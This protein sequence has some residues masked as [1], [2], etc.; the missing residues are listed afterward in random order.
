MSR[1]RHQV[2]RSAAG[3]V[4]DIAALQWEL[5]D[6]GLPR[7]QAAPLRLGAELDPETA[8]AD[9]QKR[10][11]RWWLIPLRLVGMVAS[12]LLLDDFIDVGGGGE[13]RPR[14]VGTVAA[15]SQAE[16]FVKALLHR[17]APLAGVKARWFAWSEDGDS[18]IVAQEERWDIE[19]AH[20]SPAFRWTPDD[21]R[22]ADI[23]SSARWWRRL[24]RFEFAD[25]SQVRMRQSPGTRRLLLAGGIGRRA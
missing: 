7:C 5:E 1:G 14:I 2:N 11:H 19:G 13:D 16:S 10:H 6:Q 20:Q 4:W 8:R 25:G 24:V 22:V 21:G 9:A 3:P 23:D 18:W 17:P 12:L 15:G